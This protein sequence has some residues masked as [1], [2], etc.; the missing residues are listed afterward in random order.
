MITDLKDKIIELL[1]KPLL[2]E[3][4]AIADIVLSHFKGD[5]TL[6][7]FIYSNNEMN[8]DEC[9]RVSR[10]VGDIIE[11][12]DYFEKGYTLEVSSPGLDRRLKTIVDFKYRVGENVKIE[13]VDKKT[14]KITAEIVKGVS[15]N[16]VFLPTISCKLSSAHL[17]S[18]IDA[19]ISPRP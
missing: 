11:E 18:G 9:A 8:V 14:K 15:C 16:D 6:R 3:G 17:C 7:L 13:F 2:D 12:S 5:S 10:M 1:E 4:V 19:H